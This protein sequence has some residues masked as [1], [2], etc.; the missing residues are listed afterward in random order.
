MGLKNINDIIE[1]MRDI[2]VTKEIY[3]ANGRLIEQ[4][5]SLVEKIIFTS[6]STVLLGVLSTG[7]TFILRRP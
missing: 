2:F 5:M 3:D 4:R 6:V 7:L 1:K